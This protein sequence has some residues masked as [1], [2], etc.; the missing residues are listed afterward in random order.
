MEQKQLDIYYNDSVGHTGMWDMITV[1]KKSMIW[2][3]M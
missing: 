3:H 1:R 2:Q